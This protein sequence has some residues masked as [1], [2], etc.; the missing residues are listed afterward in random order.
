MRVN[1]SRMAKAWTIASMAVAA[2][3]FF[4]AQASAT[5]DT[6][7]N[8][9]FEANPPGGASC[10]TTGFPAC[11]VGTDIS[12]ITASSGPGTASAHHASGLTVFSNPA[13]N[14]SAES[15][16][17]DHFAVGDYYQFQTS[18]TGTP[19]FSNIG[20]VFDQVSSNTGPRDFKVQYSTDGSTFLDFANNTYTVQPSDTPGWAAG[21][22]VPAGLDT[23]AFDLSGITALNNAANVY[24]RLS[25]TGVSTAGPAT[26]WAP[27]VEGPVQTGGTSRIDNVTVYGGFD[28]TAFVPAPPVLPQAGDIVFGLN[29]P[30]SKASIE[31]VRGP[32]TAGGGAEPAPFGPWRTMLQKSVR[33]D[34]L[35]GTLHNVQGNLLGIGEGATSGTSSANNGGSIWSSATQGAAPFANRQLLATTGSAPTFPV[36]KTRLSG[37]SVSPDNSKIAVVGIDSQ[38]VIVYD[39]HAGNSQGTGASLGNSRETATTDMTV[40]NA[41]GTTSSQGTA[42][43]NNNTALALATTG[44]LYEAAVTTTTVTNTL[45]ASLTLPSITPTASALYYNTAASQYIWA[46]L[47][48]F[49]GSAA[50]R[51]YVLDPAN[52]YAVIGTPY[53]L[54]LGNDTA[55]EIALNKD[56]DLF[57]STFT[58]GSTSAKIY[59]LK[60]AADAPASLNPADAT[61]WYTS[62]GV[63]FSNNNGLD[64]GFAATGI[65]G[66]YNNDNKVNAADYVIW[67]KTNINGAAGYTAWRSNFGAGGLGSGSGLGGA[68]VPEP[69]S[70]LLLVLGLAAFCPRRRSA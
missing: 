6:I 62:T 8:W 49:S 70:A 68:S 25:V 9:D 16:S 29:T 55:R 30:R 34:N 21:T 10:G 20:L 44:D 51:L 36:T 43:L 46:M 39:Y 53:D 4:S 24:F 65:A 31:L 64:V 60:D 50:N 59:V 33:F 1:L 27:G 13:G 48:G 32:S 35:G 41:G 45:K 11:P 5:N 17:S 7:S 47:S 52:N 67:R 54:S 66:D 14:G 22:A 23:F 56:G 3:A 63:P 19:S 58:S 12:G 37:L 2:T 38:K 18:T 69:T 26:G 42:W 28:S 40:T 15:F 57:I 61:L